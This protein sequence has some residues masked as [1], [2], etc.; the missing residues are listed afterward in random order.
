MFTHAP[1]DGPVSGHEWHV[2]SF[3]IITSVALIT[4]VT[5]SPFFSFNSSALRLVITDSTMLS[6]TFTV[7]RAVTVPNNTSVTSP[8]RWL[9]ALRAMVLLLFGSGRLWG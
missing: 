8:L 9:R 3:W 1:A 7:I 4:A 6:P 5:L 2:Q